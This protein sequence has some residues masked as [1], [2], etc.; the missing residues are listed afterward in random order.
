[1]R[2][3]AADAFVQLDA[4]ERAPHLHTLATAVHSPATCDRQLILH[5]FTRISTAEQI[6]HHKTLLAY[7]LRAGACARMHSMCG[8]PVVSGSGEWACPS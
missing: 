7:V 2:A 3:C 4:R 5:V 1:V 8:P 6:P